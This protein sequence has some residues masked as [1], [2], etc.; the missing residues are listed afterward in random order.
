MSRSMKSN[1]KVGKIR[2]IW[3]ETFQRMDYYLKSQKGRFILCNPFSGKFI[4]Q[5]PGLAGK[6]LDRFEKK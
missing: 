1:I 6:Q 3:N 4:Q 5:G 2:M